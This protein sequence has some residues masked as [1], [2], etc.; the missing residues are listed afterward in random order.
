MHTILLFKYIILRR[1]NLF[2]AIEFGVSRIFPRF[3]SN[4]ERIEFEHRCCIHCTV[5]LLFNFL[6]C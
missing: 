5:C 2:T 3:L 1:F 4:P 6:A